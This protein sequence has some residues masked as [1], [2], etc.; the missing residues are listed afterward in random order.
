MCFDD[1][2]TNSVTFSIMPDFHKNVKEKIK[3]VL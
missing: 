1:T 2:V 3:N